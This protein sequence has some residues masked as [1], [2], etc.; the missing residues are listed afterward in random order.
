MIR[1]NLNRDELKK[2]DEIAKQG[3]RSRS[4]FVSYILRRLIETHESSSQGDL[5][6]QQGLA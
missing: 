6:R 5:T 4:G 1:T 3:E 2:L